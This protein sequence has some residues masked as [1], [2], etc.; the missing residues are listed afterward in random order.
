MN[1]LALVDQSGLSRLELCFFL[2]LNVFLILGAPPFLTFFLK[3]YALVNLVKFGLFYLVLVR[4]SILFVYL[5]LIFFFFSL[6]R[7]I[8][9]NK[10]G[11]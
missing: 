8:E 7:V 9:R 11:V 2:G 1:K 3:V 6:S 10:E 5:Y 4:V